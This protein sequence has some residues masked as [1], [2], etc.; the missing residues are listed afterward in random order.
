MKTHSINL[1]KELV[2]NKK[3]ENHNETCFKQK[4]NM[5]NFPKGYGNT[6]IAFCAKQKYKHLPK[7]YEPA[8][9]VKEFM[10]VASKRGQREN[11]YLPFFT[12]Y[13]YSVESV[14]NYLC[15]G[16]SC[17]L[18]YTD[19][20]DVRELFLHDL[21]K[22]LDRGQNKARLF[23]LPRGIPFVK[24]NCADFLDKNELTDYMMEKV[25]EQ[26]GDEK[27]IIIADEAD[28]L[29][30]VMER[31]NDFFKASLFKK[32]PTIFLTEE[33]YKMVSQDESAVYNTRFVSAQERYSEFPD[34]EY[35]YAE[36]EKQK[37]KQALLIQNNVSLPIIKNSD[38]KKF[39][40]NPLVQ[41]YFLANGNDIRFS[42]SLISYAI[43]LANADLY[44]TNNNY[45]TN[46]QS[47]LTTQRGTALEN[48]IMLLRLAAVDAVNHSQRI[49]KKENIRNIYPYKD[50]PLI[51]KFNKLTKTLES[52]KEQMKEI[53]DIINSQAEEA[54][55]DKKTTEKEEEILEND[56]KVSIIRNPKT[57]FSDVGGMFNVKKQIK[58]EFLDIMKNDNIKNSQKPNGILLYGPPGCGKTLLAKAIAGEA[59]VP[60]VSTAGSSF[61]EIYVGTGPKGVRDLYEI[62]RNEAKKHPSKT[63]IVFIDEVDSAAGR[64]NPDSGSG[65]DLKTVNA[66]LHEMDGTKN[67]GDE[68]V[69]IITIMATNN[70]NMLDG[71]I[72]RNGR[73]DVK[74][75]IDDPR[76]SEKARREIL[77]IHAKDLPFENEEEKEKLID[78]LAKTSSGLSGADLA[79]IIKK[80]YRLSL[81]ADRENIITQDDINE[82]KMRVQTGV[83]TDIETTD[84][85]KQ[86]TVA[87]EAGKAVNSMILEKIFEGEKY[88]HKMPTM[89]LDFISNSA[90][91]GVSGSTYF[92]PS[93]NKTDSKESCF[94][95]VITLYGSYAVE[96][97]LYDT[98]TIKVYQDMGLASD[99]ISSAVMY[100]D[101]G[102][103]KR[104]LSLGSS[105][106]SSLYSE[107]IKGEIENFSQ[108]G[109]KISQQMIKFAKPFI[110]EYVNSLSGENSEREVTAEEFKAK[111]NNWLKANKK[112][113]E[114]ETLC[115]DLKAQIQDFC[116]ENEP[117]K[118][119]MGF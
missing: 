111:F 44:Y 70:K 94:A 39:L 20:M 101:F 103:S 68:D 96:T 35:S 52:H 42:L 9:D 84:Y 10:E 87:R 77:D 27:A 33:K 104:F 108:K 114:Y 19:K 79:E 8:V 16:Q 99:I 58:E 34:L 63:A 62:A 31:P 64:R 18:Y 1:V 5:T 25:E 89:V 26:V 83:K 48:A 30:D 46:Y 54:D 73:I 47:Y 55:N 85:E 76:Y 74:C 75:Y 22:T 24:F 88:K 29:F 28:T 117:E 4:C 67:K 69:K 110:E 102:S 113:E 23:G 81:R 43:S 50:A 65:E 2:L 38:A 3:K 11:S 51:E 112:E 49:V 116:K 80:A 78:N 91:G 118:T 90:R 17:L 66:L 105:N 7:M 95:D 97:Q 21:R 61:V 59:G 36:A 93:D 86:Q 115:K 14:L 106:L 109:M 40:M 72:T 45:G 119:K 15:T 53:T 60:F 12:P 13:K 6:N 107:E 71:A 82:A 98:H 57:K 37:S 100:F 92:K 32:Y 41:K 56:G